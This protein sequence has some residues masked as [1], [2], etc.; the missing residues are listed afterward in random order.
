MLSSRSFLRRAFHRAAAGK[1]NA[2][3]TTFNNSPPLLAFASLTILTAAATTDGFT[4]MQRFYEDDTT[5]TT[6]CEDSSNTS[7]IRAARLLRK[8]TAL[9]VAAASSK[10]TDSTTSTTTTTTRKN[11][12]NNINNT[13]DDGSTRSGSDGIS[14]LRR[15]T[16][17][18]QLSKLR[19]KKD[20]MLRRWDEDEDGW[21]DLPARAWPAKQPNP[22]E[23]EGIVAEIKSL[24]CNDIIVI[25]NNNNNNNNN[26]DKAD[27]NNNNN[28]N[29]ND[30]RSN[31]KKKIDDNNNEVLHCTDL[32]F[33]MATTY[34]FYNVNP[35]AGLELYER[36]ARRGH[37]DSMV[38]CGII[39]VEGL[40]GVPPK[41]REGVVWL[42]KAI[43]APGSSAQACYELGTIYYTGIDGFIEEDA[44]KAYEL[45]A[46]AAQ[47]DHT[48]ALYMTADCL[49]EGLAGVP[50]KEREGFVWLEKAIAAPGGSSAQA[51]YELGTIYYTGIDGFIEE[52]AE[53]AYELF[54]RAAQ[55]DHTAALY[56]T[57]DCL[58]EGEGVERSVA[59]A[60]PL[61]YKAADRGHR[62]SRQRIRELLA[63]C[64]YPL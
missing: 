42:E 44:E 59:K 64:D 21:R 57:A 39:L 10:M 56:M 51:C 28:D 22:E 3:K 54:E 38:A 47:Q 5:L 8:K 2:I 45:F 43:A 36:L 35:E 23:L 12:Q 20:E 6:G 62:F 60:I 31:N 16:T 17:R 55:Q 11:S 58:V 33:D 24:S 19:V 26:N 7:P 52:D 37:V 18:E 14:I 41:E 50:P 30:N 27:D 25:D 48:A 29:D 61:F 32:L 49:V 63:R 9:Q 40:A 1:S 15:L 53:K 46:R 34:V 13:D 4:N